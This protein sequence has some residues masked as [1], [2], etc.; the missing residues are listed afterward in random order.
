[1]SIVSHLAERPDP[2]L[3]VDF[4]YSLRDPGSPREPAKILFLERLASIFGGGANVKGELKLFLTGGEGGE[5][6]GLL[7]GVDLP[8]KRRR[9]AIEDVAAA[10]GDD[11]RGVVVYVCGVP[12]MTDDFVK[13]LTSPKGLGLEPHRVLYEKWW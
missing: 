4:L 5:D 13:K 12:K 3:G 2:R 8:F 1:M 6:D 10:V 9:I 11:K 7:D